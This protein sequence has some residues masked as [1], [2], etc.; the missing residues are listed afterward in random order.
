[1]KSYFDRIYS[2]DSQVLDKICENIL[3]RFYH[4]INELII[5]PNSMECM[6]RTMDYPQLHSLT[7][8][9]FSEVSLSNHIT[10]NT[11][12]RKLLQQITCLT[13]DVKD[14]PTKEHCI[15]LGDMFASILRLCKRITKLS[16]CQ[17]DNRTA[18][19]SF[20]IMPRKFLFSTLTELKITVEII[21]DCLFLLDG[22]LDC[23]STFVIEIK[24]ILYP[25]AVIDNTVSILIDISSN[26]DQLFS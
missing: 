18:Y 25:V 10:R 7:L 8:L 6:L 16:F 24:I 14:E 20:D 26:K 4:Q 1:M 5:E 15:F 21:D 22:R 11:I 3:P 2:I 13:I 19:C 17:L 12:L 23:L 9:D